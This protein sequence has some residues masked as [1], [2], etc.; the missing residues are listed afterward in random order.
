M[1]TYVDDPSGF[2]VIASNAGSEHD[3]AWWGNLVADPRA[4][5]RTGRVTQPVRMRPLEGEARE[6]AWA[7]AVSGYAGYAGYASKA[8]RP[9]PVALLEIVSE[10]PGR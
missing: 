6:R 2:V 1:L 9:I 5:V 3:P 7:R 10:G 8:G 4:T